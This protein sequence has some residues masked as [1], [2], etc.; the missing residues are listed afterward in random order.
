MRKRKFTGTKKLFPN[1]WQKFPFLVTKIFAFTYVVYDCVNTVF[2]LV[3]LLRA[4]SGKVATIV[5]FLFRLRLLKSFRR[6]TSRLLW[7]LSGCRQIYVE[8]FRVPSSVKPYQIV[9]QNSVRTTITKWWPRAAITLPSRR[10]WPFR[11]ANFSQW[12]LRIPIG[13][14]GKRIALFASVK[15]AA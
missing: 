15:C 10:E 3:T 12:L 8:L 4:L 5:P 14:K 13:I 7:Y 11:N 9:M 1:R 2:F 6:N